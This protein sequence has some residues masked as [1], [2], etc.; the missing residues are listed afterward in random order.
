MNL[1]IIFIYKLFLSKSREIYNENNQQ[2]HPQYS[3]S[4]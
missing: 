4:G 3:L 2:K 1:N